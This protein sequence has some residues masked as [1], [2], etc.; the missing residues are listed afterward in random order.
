[1]LH[2][3]RDHS[4]V[5]GTLEATACGATSGWDVVTCSRNDPVALVSIT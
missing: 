3:S 1:M 2:V 4:S 5:K